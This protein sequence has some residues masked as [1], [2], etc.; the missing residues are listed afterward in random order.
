MQSKFD[1]SSSEIKISDPEFIKHQK[2]FAVYTHDNAA[3]KN[4]KLNLIFGMTT[5][6]L[7][8]L[9]KVSYETIILAQLIIQSVYFVCDTLFLFVSRRNMARTMIELSEYN[10]RVTALKDFE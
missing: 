4:S 7:M 10:R 5:V 8:I 3:Y 6:F 1:L 2:V 9:A